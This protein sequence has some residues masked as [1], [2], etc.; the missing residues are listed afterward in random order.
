MNG[1]EVE[2]E[3]KKSGNG[4]KIG[5]NVCSREGSHMAFL[6]VPDYPTGPEGQ[7][8]TRLCR[9]AGP[10][11]A[12]SRGPGLVLRSLRSVVTQKVPHS[13]CPASARR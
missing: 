11:F 3:K 6:N 4:R 2:M 9:W 5:K 10:G 1:L 12:P 8:R 7:S 13:R